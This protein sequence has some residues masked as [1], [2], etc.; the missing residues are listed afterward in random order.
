MKTVGQLLQ[1]ARENNFYSLEEIEKATKIRKELLEALEKGQYDKLPPQ[2]FIQGFIK[3]YAKFLK[4]D[5]EKLLAVFRRE[6]AEKEAEV[7]KA[8]SSPP[9]K[10]R[11]ILTPSRAVGLTVGLVFLS[12][13][14]YLWIQYHQLVG[15]PNLAVATPQ[16][17][18][19]VEVPQVVVEGKTDPEAKVAINN[20]DVPLSDEGVFKQEI[21]LSGSVNKI[22]VSSQS[23]FGQKTI[24]ERTVYVKR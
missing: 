23:K 20:Q 3:N 14:T 11:L 24:I 2:T 7:M 5:S 12:F 6:F 9:K 8:F 21:K 22:T 16:D 4:L 18:L 17:Q 13:F 1:E 15:A 19:T 10:T